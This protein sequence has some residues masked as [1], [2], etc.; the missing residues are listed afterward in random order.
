[1][2]KKITQKFQFWQMEKDLN[3]AVVGKE[4][5]EFSK[6]ITKENIENFEIITEE[7]DICIVPL[8][9]IARGYNI[10][11]NKKFNSESM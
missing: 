1:M 11:T 9:I 10:L 6:V 2:A 4:E 7:A 3:Y 8:S 5:N